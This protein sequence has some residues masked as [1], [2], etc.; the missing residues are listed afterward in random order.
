MD[1]KIFFDINGNIISIL[2]NKEN[3]LNNREYNNI[4][5]ELIFV[6]LYLNGKRLKGK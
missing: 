2:N 5:C 1:W 4:N 3:G 6:G